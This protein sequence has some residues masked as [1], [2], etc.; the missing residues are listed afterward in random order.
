MNLIEET[1]AFCKGWT[2]NFYDGRDLSRAEV[3]EI[4]VKRQDAVAILEKIFDP[5]FKNRWNI[6]YVK[7]DPRILDGSLV[8]I[9]R[10]DSISEQLQRVL[11]EY[12]DHPYVRGFV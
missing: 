7:S 1:L 9:S 5:E 2:E 8:A 3:T 4:L 12:K 10:L 11:S 6:P